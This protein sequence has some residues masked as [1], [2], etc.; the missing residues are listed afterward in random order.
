V[1]FTFPTDLPNAVELVL[2]AVF[3]AVEI[4]V[5]TFEVST[6]AVVVVVLVLR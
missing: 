1:K 4:L 2:I 6:P 5:V 3:P